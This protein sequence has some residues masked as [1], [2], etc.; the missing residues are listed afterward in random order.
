MFLVNWLRETFAVVLPRVH[1][2]NGAKAEPMTIYANVPGEIIIC[3]KQWEIERYRGLRIGLKVVLY[4]LWE[5]VL[6][7]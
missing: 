7:H 4:Y 5:A 6:R 2:E 3:N 1:Q